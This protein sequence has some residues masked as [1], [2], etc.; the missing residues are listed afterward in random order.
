[1]VGTASLGVFA[2]I[3]MMFWQKVQTTKQLLELGVP[4]AGVAAAV[5]MALGNLLVMARGVHLG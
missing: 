1:M 2:P 3:A 5:A 4:R